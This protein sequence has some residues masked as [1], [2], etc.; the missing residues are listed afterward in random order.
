MLE[1]G[2]EESNQENVKFECEQKIFHIKY[3]LLVSTIG[4]NVVFS[5]V[6]GVY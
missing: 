2:S 3:K 5:L 6:K 4:Y 1:K